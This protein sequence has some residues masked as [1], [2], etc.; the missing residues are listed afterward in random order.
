[1]YIVCFYVFSIFFNQSLVFTDYM[2]VHMYP[3][4]QNTL[5]PIFYLLKSKKIKKK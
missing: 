3:A 2:C 1:M 4:V 5:P